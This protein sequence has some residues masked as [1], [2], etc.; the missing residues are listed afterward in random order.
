MVLDRAA[1]AA[2]ELSRAGSARALGP[3]DDQQSVLPAL[4]AV[5]IA[6][7]GDPCHLRNGCFEPGGD[8]RRLFAG[9]AGRTART[10]AAFRS[11]SHFGDALRP[12]LHVPRE[13][14]PVD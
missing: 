13:L 5:G 7:D 6:A 10:A 1:V 3:E 2:P 14:V 11:A 12:D 8:H 4:S 9:A